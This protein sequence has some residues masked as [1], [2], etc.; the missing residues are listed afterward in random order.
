MTKL[1]LFLRRHILWVGFL[2]VFIPLLAMLWMQYRSLVELERTSAVADKMALKNHLKP[3]ISEIQYFYRANA[4]QALNISAGALTDQCLSNPGCCFRNRKWEGAK[5]LFLASFNKHGET[6]ILFYTPT[7]HLME[8]RPNSLESRAVSVACAPWRILGIEGTPIESVNLNVDERDPENR[9]I[10][11]PITDPSMKVVGV[12]GLIVD[13]RFFKERYLPRVIANSYPNLF[14]NDAHSCL[15]ITVR[16]S[17]ERLLYS[18]RPPRSGEDEMWMTVPFIFTDWR[19]GVQTGDLTPEQWARRN[20]TTNLSLSIL[21]TIILIGGIILALRAASREMKLS[22][23]KTDFVSNV[24]HELRTPLSSI[25]VFGEFLKLGRVRTEKIRE[26]G[27]YIETE[28]RRLTQL[29]NNILDFSK[30]ESVQKNYHFEKADLEALIAET[31]KTFEVSLIQNRFT[32]DFEPPDSPLPLAIIDPDAIVQAF[33]N[34][35]DNA[36]KYSGSSKEIKIRLGQVNGFITVS[37]ADYG[38][39][40]PKED[41]EKIFEKFYRVSTGL[42]HDVKG[43]GLGLSIVKHIVEAHRGKVIVESES[44]KGSTFT[45]YLPS[46]EERREPQRHKEHKEFLIFLCALCV[47]VVSLPLFKISGIDVPHIQI[48]Y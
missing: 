37:V 25:R 28:S 4:E 11:K 9:I 40:I 44:G 16:D 41:R 24:S 26:Y 33:T 42:V 7:S 29:I 31:L 27:E 19:V 46:G 20:F 22:Q 38:I 17:A 21:M 10:L 43:N 47:F 1:N 48:V 39:G 32:V 23:M 18:T 13:N 5:R 8:M 34:L 30:I 2:A 6:E 45:I 3:I 15:I 12:A 14:E 36:V 35:I